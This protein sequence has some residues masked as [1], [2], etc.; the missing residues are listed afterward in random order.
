MRHFTR[1]S[2][3]TRSWLAKLA[4]ENKQVFSEFTK[5]NSYCGISFFFF[6]L[7]LFFT[8][9]WVVPVVIVVID[10]EQGS[11]VWSY[12]SYSLFIVAVATVLLTVTA[13]IIYFNVT[14]IEESRIIIIVFTYSQILPYFY[15]LPWEQCE[16]SSLKFRKL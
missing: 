16:T 2:P 1:G 7:G 14:I 10:Q 8:L 9:F 13:I 6:I 3:R 12:G 4:K 11:H 15:L 5:L